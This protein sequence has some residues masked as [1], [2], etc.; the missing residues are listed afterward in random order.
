M[1]LAV[2]DVSG[3]ARPDKAA[4]AGTFALTCARM[5]LTHGKVAWDDGLVDPVT[6]L[7]MSSAGSTDG[8][9]DAVEVLS[10]L[11]V[12]VAAGARVAAMAEACLPANEAMLREMVAA[13][14]AGSPMPGS[15]FDA[16]WVAVLRA[17]APLVVA[18]GIA[19]DAARLVDDPGYEPMTSAARAIDGIFPQFRAEPLPAPAPGP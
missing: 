5:F 16:G 10:G 19:A 18:S 11:G 1:F 7:A 13:A 15:D 14:E 9:P 17:D 3:Y 12:G 2:P 4:G 6:L 8:L